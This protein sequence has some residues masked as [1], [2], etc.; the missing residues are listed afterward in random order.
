[1]HD[2]AAGDA[3]LHREAR[4][5]NLEHEGGPALVHSHLRARAEAE[6]GELHP[7]RGLAVHLRDHARRPRPDVVQSRGRGSGDGGPA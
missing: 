5:T 4:G 7:Q 6:V 1:M 2:H 3:R